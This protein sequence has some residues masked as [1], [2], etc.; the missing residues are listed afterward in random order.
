MMTAPPW[1]TRDSALSDVY[2][3]ECIPLS[4]DG[5]LIW[6]SR[7]TALELADAF[8]LVE[9]YGR[10]VSSVV[11]R[12]E[13]LQ[14]LMRGSPHILS[15]ENLPEHGAAI[16]WG[17]TPVYISLYMKPGYSYVLSREGDS[18]I[19]SRIVGPCNVYAFTMEGGAAPAF[20]FRCEEG[21]H[22]PT[23][24]EVSHSVKGRK[25]HYHLMGRA[26]QE[27]WLSRC[28]LQAMETVIGAVQALVLKEWES[29][30]QETGCL[31]VC[32]TLVW[33]QPPMDFKEELTWDPCYP[34]PYRTRLGGPAPRTSA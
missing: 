5:A 1:Q 10:T 19:Y 34:P 22:Y 17:S 9:K 7:I 13:H 14:E 12:P 23:V 8:A 33:V 2:G 25:D 16:L 28:Q 15:Y 18:L 3:L 20:T 30:Y 4:P 6:P 11:M 29:Y 31:P 26:A 21:T 32:I 24:Q 27:E